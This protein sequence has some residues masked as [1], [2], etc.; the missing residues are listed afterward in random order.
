LR[1]VPKV[2]E[3]G[4]YLQ[5]GERKYLLQIIETDASVFKGSLRQG[6]ITLTLFQNADP[7]ERNKAIKTILS[8]LVAKDFLPYITQ[9]VTEINAQYFKKEIKAVRLKYNHSNWGSCST[10]RN[11]NL[12]TRLLFAPNPVIDYVIVHELAHLYEMNHSD[13]FW[14]IVQSVMPEYQKCE[15]WLKKNGNLCEF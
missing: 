5:V 9:K 4:N 2:Y 15:K 6:T 10:D 7:R 14:Q 1:F 13:R 8:R 11:I 12:S 3:S